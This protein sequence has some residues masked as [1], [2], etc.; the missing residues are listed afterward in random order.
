MQDFTIQVKTFSKWSVLPQSVTEF[1][2]F[3]ATDLRLICTEGDGL[4]G[5]SPPEQSEGLHV[6]PPLCDLSDSD[7]SV[8]A[9]NFMV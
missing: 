7:V 6:A 2:N 4:C 5:D 1:Q 3:Y 8:V 9:K